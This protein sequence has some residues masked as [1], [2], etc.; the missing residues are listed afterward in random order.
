MPAGSPKDIA[1][2][3]GMQFQHVFHPTLQ[4]NA[5][6]FAAFLPDRPVGHRLRAPARRRWQLCARAR[7]LSA[8]CV[9][10][11]TDLRRKDAAN[12]QPSNPAYRR[13]A[14]A[15]KLGAVGNAFISVTGKI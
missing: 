12:L 9:V 1:S 14:G 5:G 2:V 15:A 6:T 11:Q 10:P 7:V 13:C 3:D 8:T 4:P